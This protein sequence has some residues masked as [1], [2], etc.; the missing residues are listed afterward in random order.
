M[1]LVRGVAVV[2]LAFVFTGCATIVNGR[3][4]EIYVSTQPEGAKALSAEDSCTTPCSLMLVRKDPGK[5][6][7]K[8][9]GYQT[10]QIPVYEKDRESGWI[11][12]NFISWNLLGLIVDSTNGSTFE[13][14]PESIHMPLVK[15][16][17]ETPH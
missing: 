6:L 14:Q 15:A 2:M 3:K 12:L 17:N 1:R 4:Q 10:A 8:L 7:I 9:D 16:S 5:I 13:L 11:W